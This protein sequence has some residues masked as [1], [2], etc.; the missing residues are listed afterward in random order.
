VLLNSTYLFTYLLKCGQC[1]VDSRGVWLNTDLFGCG[2]GRWAWWCNGQGVG[3]VFEGSRVRSKRSRFHVTTLG[4]LFAHTCLCYPAV[5]PRG[6]EGNRR[7][8]VA[9]AMRHR[10]QWFIQ[11]RAH[12]LRQGDEPPPT[13]FMGYYTGY[14]TFSLGLGKKVAHNRLPSVEFQ[15]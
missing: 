13:L 2:L 1:H 14:F 6:W 4:K 8:G 7:S 9:L 5:T 11:L 12:G 15:S 10:L 3:L